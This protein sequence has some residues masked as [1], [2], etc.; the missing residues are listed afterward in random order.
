[1]SPHL[2]KVNQNLPHTKSINFQS[3]SKFQ[4]T[5]FSITGSKVQA[6]LKMLGLSDD[7]E[8]SD[9]ND[10]END[11]LKVDNQDLSSETSSSPELEPWL[12]E[13]ENEEKIPTVP[14][15]EIK[16]II[17]EH[18]EEEILGKLYRR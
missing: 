11:N 10:F 17:E 16:P 5:Y 7:D 12:D 18:K 8:N 15:N 13:E 4:I 6:K 14:P 1:M 9:E 3:Q 2:K